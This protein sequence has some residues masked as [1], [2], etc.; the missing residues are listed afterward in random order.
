VHAYRV[1]K[2][3]QRL[4]EGKELPET[5][6]AIQTV[7]TQEVE[8]KVKGGKKKAPRRKSMAAMKYTETYENL[9]KPGGKGR[10]RAA[11]DNLGPELGFQDT[12]EFPKSNI[13]MPANNLNFDGLETQQPVPTME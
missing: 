10:S 4:K 5:E 12:S 8:V 1:K 3:Q 6:E 7:P 13:L 9:T 2:A 11:S